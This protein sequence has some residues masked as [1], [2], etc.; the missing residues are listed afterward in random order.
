VH[1]CRLLLIATVAWFAL[2]APSAW[3]ATIVTRSGAVVTLQT[4]SAAANETVW[5]MIR[6]GTLRFH[7]SSFTDVD[8]GSGCS[9]DPV[10]TQ[11]ATCG[12]GASVGRIDI[13]MGGGDDSVETRAAETGDVLDLQAAIDADMGTGDDVLSVDDN[14]QAVVGQGSDGSDFLASGTAAD[15]LQGGAGNDSLGGGL[16]SDELFGGPDF[17]FAFYSGHTTNLRLSLNGMRDDG[18][19]AAGEA[20]LLDGI[21]S[22]QG[23]SGDDIITGDDGLNDLIG[24]QGSDRLD[25]RGGFDRIDGDFS[26]SGTGNDIIFARDGL[27]DTIDCADGD[28]I[29]TAD[30]VDISFECEDRQSIPDL[31]PDRDGDGIDKPLD[32]NDLDGTVRPGAFDRPGDGVDQ[33]CDGADAVD[34]DRDRDGV[35]AGFDCDDG[36]RD[37]HPGARERLGN[38]V[39]EDCDGVNDPFPAFPTEA[40]LAARLG[41]V[42]RVVGLVLVDLEGRERVRITCKRKGCRFKARRARAGRRAVSLILDRQ[43]R[44][45]RMQPG[46]QLIVRVTRRDGVRKLFTFTARAGKP[47]KQRTRCRAPRGGRVARC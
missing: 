19:Q 24:G 1:G 47:P 33:N 4:T 8:A 40:A 45:L 26:G 42:T 10:T 25:G 43:V 32:C 46:A 3:A 15:R 12:P 44:G 22:L 27:A 18:D 37:I 23:G 34:N 29:L 11:D 16:G 36:N 31:Q 2:T 14:S 28:D 39:D 6:G 9:N 21:E 30:D 17:D 38:R 20:D 35:V 13:R 7:G 41:A 5:M